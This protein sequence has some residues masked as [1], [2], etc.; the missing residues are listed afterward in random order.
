M[1]ENSQYQ[2]VDESGIS[3]IDT[4][5]FLKQVYFKT[6]IIYPNF[7]HPLGVEGL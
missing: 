7:C 1:A 3:I 2:R 5:Y 4:R 6:R